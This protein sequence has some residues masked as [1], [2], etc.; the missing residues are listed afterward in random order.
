M[1]KADY[2]DED[3]N[4]VA[5]APMIASAVVS[6]SD[7]VGSGRES[8][9]EEL[10]AFLDYIDTAIEKHQD[11]QLILDVIEALQNRD[12]L[13]IEHKD[14]VFNFSLTQVERLDELMENVR[15]AARMVGR[16]GDAADLEAYSN[17]IYDAAEVVANASKESRMIMAKKVSTKE[18]FYLRRL[19]SILQLR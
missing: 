16:T 3:W 9:D 7:D 14:M 4:L 1:S 15:D 5:A 19:R 8:E 6:V 17:F 13:E 10:T 11:C 18:A 12:A 2:S